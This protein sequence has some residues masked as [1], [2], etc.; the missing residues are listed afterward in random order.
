MVYYIE[1]VKVV[2]AS[3]CCEFQNVCPLKPATIDDLA[4]LELQ[5]IQH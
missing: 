1:M 4:I 2:T 3:E 5:K